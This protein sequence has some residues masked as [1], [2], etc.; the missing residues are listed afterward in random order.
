[1]T[2]VKTYTKHI[3]KSKSKYNGLSKI[4]SYELEYLCL[5][6]LNKNF[7]CICQNKDN[8]HFPKIININESELKFTF[9]H[10]GKSLNRLFYKINILNYEKQVDCI[11]HNLKKNNIVHLDMVSNG[12]NL[13]ITDD[14]ILSLID[15]DIARIN[16]KY[17][18][19]KIEKR[20]TNYGNNYD[21]YIK[22]FR[23]KILSILIKHKYIIT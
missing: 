17:L 14:G 6:K 15:F 10:C 9:S 13:C 3:I 23:Q 20:F 1:M 11:I 22:Q 2:T 21:D 18:S 8:H 5:N 12:K 16:N 7:V 19:A 4:E